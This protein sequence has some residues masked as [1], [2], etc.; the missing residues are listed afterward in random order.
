MY[1]QAAIK[2]NIIPRNG[3]YRIVN[4]DVHF[5][6]PPCSSLRSKNYTSLSR[7]TLDTA[8]D[9]CMGSG[10]ILVYAFDVFM[11]IYENAGW[12]QRDAAQSII[13]NN[14]YGLDIDDRAAQL[15][16]FAVLMKARQYDRES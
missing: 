16:Y 6:T 4:R 1:A 15:S 8:T 5:C 3:A 10:H 13:Q 2:R 7:I 14:I 9:P 11:Q 12:S